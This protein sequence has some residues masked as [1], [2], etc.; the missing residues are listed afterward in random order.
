M[1][2]SITILSCWY[3]SK[4]P[5]RQHQNPGI[6]YHFVRLFWCLSRQLVVSQTTTVLC[7]TNCYAVCDLGISFTLI[8]PSPW[9]TVL[10]VSFVSPSS[11]HLKGLSLPTLALFFHNDWSRT[12]RQS[13]LTLIF[14]D[15]WLHVIVFCVHNFSHLSFPLLPPDGHIYI[16]TLTLNSTP[17]C[18]PA[19][20]FPPSRSLLSSP[21]LPPSLLSLQGEPQWDWEAEAE[22][23]DCLHHRIVRHGANLQCTGT[24]TGQT[25]HP[26]NGRFSH[27][28]TERKWQYQRRWVVQTFFS[29]GPGMS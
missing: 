17:C 3:P 24:E 23:D 2:W 12:T 26:P 19:C 14:I 6:F 7:V 11:G 9:A 8:I 28:V 10:S 27:E 13:L 16:A 18:P 25:N 29:H 22:Q 5:F 4:L 21:P 20:L 1:H 15:H